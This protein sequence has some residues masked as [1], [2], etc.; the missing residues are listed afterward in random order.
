MVNS[1]NKHSYNED[2]EDNC[3]IKIDRMHSGDSTECN[4]SPAIISRKSAS[5]HCCDQDGNDDWF[6]T[7]T[8]IP[9]AEFDNTCSGLKD[10]LTRGNNYYSNNK[11]DINKNT[12]FLIT[13]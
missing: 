9:V 3:S 2:D 11:D 13:L 6:D 1:G 10:L 8:D 7:E 12:F 4:V 5:T